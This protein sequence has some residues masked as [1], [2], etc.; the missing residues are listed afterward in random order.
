MHACD[1]HDESAINWLLLVS[2]II[3]IKGE[4]AEKG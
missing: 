3:D 2:V 4:H 1:H